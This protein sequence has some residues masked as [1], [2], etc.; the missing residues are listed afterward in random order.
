VPESPPNIKLSGQMCLI[1][2]GWLHNMMKRL[3]TIACGAL[4]L[5]SCG[6]NV[7][8][9]VVRKS[10]AVPIAQRFA[11]AKSLV[12]PGMLTSEVESL[13][14]EPSRRVRHNPGLAPGVPPEEHP[15]IN[16]WH[17]YSYPGGTIRLHFLQVMDAP[18]FQAE[19]QSMEM[20]TKEANHNLH[21]IP[22]RADAVREG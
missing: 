1:I 5:C 10:D 8:E 7:D 15:R 18:R 20:T 19:F 16:W 6:Q 17:E 14:G 22:N 3:S 2:N 9:E 11:T 4:L 21:P 12:T 13:L